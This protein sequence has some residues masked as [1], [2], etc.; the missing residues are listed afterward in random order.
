VSSTVEVVLQC[1]LNETFWVEVVDELVAELRKL[2]EWHSRLERP[3]VR[4]CDLLL[5]LPQ[6]RTRL[7]DH[8]DEAAGSLG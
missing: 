3:G 7:A 2:E 4:I 8:L 1:S 6:G 5:R